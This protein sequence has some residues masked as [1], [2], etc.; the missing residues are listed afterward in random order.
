M[1]LEND[2]AGGKKCEKHLNSRSNQN[3]QRLID[4]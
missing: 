3:K 1:D 2:M 4:V